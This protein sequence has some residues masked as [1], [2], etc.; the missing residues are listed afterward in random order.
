MTIFKSKE[1]SIDDI[2]FIAA[3]YSEENDNILVHIIDEHTNRPF[4]DVQ[5]NVDAVIDTLYV[6]FFD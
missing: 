1:Q 3:K 6:K 4:A 2:V 5:T